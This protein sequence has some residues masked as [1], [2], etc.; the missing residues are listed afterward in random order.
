MLTG[1]ETGWLTDADEAGEAALD[2]LRALLDP[3]H[4]DPGASAAL[5]LR[6][7]A[8]GALAVPPG[9]AA[10]AL[11]AAPGKPMSAVRDRT[12]SFITDLLR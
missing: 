2:I 1:S 8:P 6:L 7:L 12:L 3:Q 10:K 4:G 9:A 11:P 5:V